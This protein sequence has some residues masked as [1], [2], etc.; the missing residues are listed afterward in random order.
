MKTVQWIREVHP[1]F[2]EDYWRLEVDGEPAPARVLIFCTV[3]YGM[4]ASN[5]EQRQTVLRLYYPHVVRLPDQ[6]NKGDQA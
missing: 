5:W 1:K 2:G 3:M 6:I 4:Q